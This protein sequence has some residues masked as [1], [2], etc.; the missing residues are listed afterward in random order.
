MRPTGLRGMSQLS[1]AG[2]AVTTSTRPAAAP[3]TLGMGGSSRGL[4]PFLLL[5]VLVC[6]LLTMLLLLL[7]VPRLR[8][9]LYAR[10]APNR[11]P[12][13]APASL[14]QQPVRSRAPVL[15]LPCT[16]ACRSSFRLG[17]PQLHVAPPAQQRHLSS[18]IR[19]PSWRRCRRGGAAACG[20]TGPSP[21]CRCASGDARGWRPAV[22]REGCRARAVHQRQR[23]RVQRP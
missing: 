1:H 16:C 14:R 20:R 3:R 10:Q 4:V 13:G 7:L 5:A 12:P 23:Q 9:L 17:A 15:Q 6:I 21:P 18:S 8:R 2:P 22:R 11:Q 19:S